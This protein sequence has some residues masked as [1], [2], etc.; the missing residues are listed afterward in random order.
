[1][2]PRPHIVV[3]P[4]HADVRGQLVA[5]EGHKELPFE[6]KRVYYMT[7]MTSDLP[8]GFH[9]HRNLQQIAICLAGSCRFV[10]DDGQ[11]KQEF[12]LS[13]S[14]EGLYIGN[15]IWREMHDFS[16]DCILLVL[17]SEKYDENDYIREY[18]IFAEEA[19]SREK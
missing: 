11:E 8:R 14:D 18:S 12:R 7:G 6:I 5:L 16:S 1:M 2:S 3:L 13:R 4:S 19:N 10:V 15:Y 17:A 9:A